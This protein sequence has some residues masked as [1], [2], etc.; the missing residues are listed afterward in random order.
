MKKWYRKG[1]L[2]KRGKRSLAL[3]LS[4]CLIGTMIPVTARAESGNTNTGLCEHHT[5]HTAECGYVEDPEGSPCTYVC[6]ICAEEAKQGETNVI[7]E[8]NLTVHTQEQ[9][10]GKSITA[11]QWVDEEEYLDEETGNLALPGASEEMPAHFDD[12]TALLPTQI[13]ATVENAENTEAEAANAEYGYF[14]AGED[15]K[16]I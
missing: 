3:L 15:I 11:W 8:E 4:V 5:E 13:Q 9:T 6:D 10:A 12:I 16:C 2:Y 7:P 14:T 1:Q